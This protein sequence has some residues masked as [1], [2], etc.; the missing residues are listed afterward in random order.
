MGHPSELPFFFGS[1]EEPLFGVLHRP[2]A[3]PPGP[4]HG[5]LICAP[6]AHEHLFAHR[7]LVELAR[8]LAAAGAHV[9]RFDYRGHGDSAGAF[10]SHTFASM[11]EDTGLA[12]EELQ[13]RAGVPCR[14]LV[15]LR[16]GAALAIEAA[17]KLGTSPALVL[18]EPVVQ[19]DKHL[20]EILRVVMSKDVANA[21][22]PRTRAELRKVLSEGGE[23]VLEGHT[24]TPGW[25]R[26][27]M[28]LDLHAGGPW[29]KGQSLTLQLPS[30]RSTNVRKELEAVRG[31]LEAAGGAAAL[32]II[33]T[34]CLW[35]GPLTREFDARNRPAGVL[36]RTVS[37]VRDAAA[38]AAPPS[39]APAAATSTSTSAE[40]PGSSERAVTFLAG[41]E[42]TP[43]ILHTP[44]EDRR[45]PVV[46]MLP[47]GMNRRIGW[48]RLYV[49]IART[50]AG[51][52]IPVLR[53]DARGF[54]DAPGVVEL[55]T[56]EDVFV[57]VQ[58]GLHNP[59]STAAIDFARSTLGPRPVVL[60]GVCGGAV[61]AGLIAPADERVVGVACVETE[62]TYTTLVEAE[63]AEYRVWEKLRDPEKWLRLLSLKADYKQHLRSLY[64]IVEKRVRARLFPSAADDT[65]WL[66]D[67][68]GA[69]VNRPL[70]AG[71]IR[72]FER[73]IPLLLV[74]GSTENEKAF[75]QVRDRLLA[76]SANTRRFVRDRVLAGADHDFL[77]RKHADALIAL[78]G[79]WIT[80]PTQ[81]WARGG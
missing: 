43:G 70:F 49:R 60:I 22:K 33:S 78:L 36:D 14:A 47:Q 40:G 21:G 75:L 77:E 6:F 62:L 66:T 32:E 35:W 39:E 29:P 69:T 72:C 52:G 80:D 15:G 18:W 54:G 67:A 76:T 17:A 16:L 19:G 51:R 34:P 9:L 11:R 38:G 64:R 71:L 42:L 13:R 30:G 26:S 81:P 63:E 74:F 8:R 45:G 28:E 4:G 31:A 48:N 23:V 68:L 79:D 61:T 5:V 12:L 24:L 50:L 56:G 10:E 44:A 7:V 65:Q 3:P 58:K 55:A 27:L 2:A 37:F 25:Y 73:P 1:R 57:A 53:F 20:D 59:D 41:A 46:V